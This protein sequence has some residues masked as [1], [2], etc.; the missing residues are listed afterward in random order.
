[1][2]AKLKMVKSDRSGTEH[3]HSLPLARAVCE[4]IC[5]KGCIG[6]AFKRCILPSITNA[7]DAS[8]LYRVSWLHDCPP[9]RKAHLSQGSSSTIFGAATLT[10]KLQTQ[11]AISPN[12][13]VH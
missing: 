1:M 7:F 6:C 8:S 12:H 13:T 9:A 2:Y 4:I 11:L 3:F 5:G 10:W